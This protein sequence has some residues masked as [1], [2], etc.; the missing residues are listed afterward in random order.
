MS[1]IFTAVAASPAAHTWVVEWA[2]RQG[3]EVLSDAE[4]ANAAAG[5][6]LGYV[7]DAHREGYLVIE[8]DPIKRFQLPALPDG[9]EFILITGAVR[10]GFVLRHGGAIWMG[11]NLAGEYTPTY[12]WSAMDLE[13]D[14]FMAFIR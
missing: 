11:Y 3:G 9:A 8:K 5:T 10:W 1:G 2:R 14:A 7:K 13:Y 6:F 12:V 4:R